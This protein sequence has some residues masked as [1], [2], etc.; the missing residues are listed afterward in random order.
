[1]LAFKSATLSLK[2]GL[3]LTSAERRVDY[4]GKLSSGFQF[5]GNLR[6]EPKTVV[7]DNDLLLCFLRVPDDDVGVACCFEEDQ[8]RGHKPRFLLLPPLSFHQ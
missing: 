3:A 2:L 4:F 1:M 8:G 5:R 7:N 6:A